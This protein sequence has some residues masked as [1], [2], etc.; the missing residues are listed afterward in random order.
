MDGSGLGLAIVKHIVGLHGGFVTFV[1]KES[2]GTTFKIFL[3][4]R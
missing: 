3:P 4:A 2:K 1:S